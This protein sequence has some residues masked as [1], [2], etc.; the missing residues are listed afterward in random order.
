[1]SEIYKKIVYPRIGLLGNPSDGFGGKTISTPFKNFQ[2]EVVLWPS[3]TLKFVPNEQDQEEFESVAQMSQVVKKTGYYG[4]IRLIKSA[5][6]TFADYCDKNNIAY[7]REKNFTVSYRTNIPRQS[8]LAGSSAIITATIRALMDLW[9]IS[10]KDIPDAVLAN[11]ILAAETDSLGIAAG[12][13]DRVVQAYSKPIYMD[14]SAEAYKKNRGLHGAYKVMADEDMPDLLLAWCDKPSESGKVHSDI[15]ARFEKRDPEV[16]K[17][18]EKFANIAEE[19]YGAIREKDRDKLHSLMNKNF[20]LRR[21]LYGDKV[22]GRDNIKMVDLARSLGAA[23]KFPG[24]GGAI[25]ILPKRITDDKIII[26]VFKE[27]GYLIERVII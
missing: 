12:L 17:A 23:A 25:V 7:D 26:K 5:I 18:M 14:F 21:K 4:G 11:I 16:I 13:Q 24:S 22:V 20:N 8:G 27:N 1:M 3:Q 10:K 9:R 2:A 19:G 15:K 6:V